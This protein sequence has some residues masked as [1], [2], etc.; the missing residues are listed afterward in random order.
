MSF[1]LL[2][3]N[4]FVTVCYL[5]GLLYIYL[6]WKRWL[7]NGILNS[8]LLIVSYNLEPEYERNLWLN[9][10]TFRHLAD[11]QTLS[12]NNEYDPIMILKNWVI[13]IAY[14]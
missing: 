1:V 8:Q 7:T 5:A 10:F 2:S 14:V 3:L 11:V 6:S 13:L 4:I 12:S 9:T